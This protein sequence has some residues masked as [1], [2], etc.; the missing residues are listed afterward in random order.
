[1][2]IDDLPITPVNSGDR[3]PLYQQVE[4]DLR[5]L[6]RLGYLTPGEALPPEVTLSD[7]YGV[8]R[9]TVR[10]ALAH[11]VE[12]DLIERYAG[13]G[14]FVKKQADRMKFYLDRSFTN[15]MA[16]LDMAAHSRVLEQSTG[17]IT[18]QSPQALRSR[19]GEPCL[20]LTRLRLGDDEPIGLQTATV[21]TTG[22]PTL[23]EVDFATHSLYAALA[24]RCKLFI[25][26]IHHTVSAAVAGDLHANLLHI[27]QGEPLLVVKTVAH[28][29]SGE[30]IEVT[31]SFYRA[32]KYE[33]ST[34]HTY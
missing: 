24:E 27:A 30:V 7:V 15:Q 21:I 3:V 31:T 26:E 6:I 33:Y 11:L 32:D 1:M 8:G 10:L 22:C 20:R 2:H 16:A 23:A 9:Q 19:M 5:R 28:L 14:T 17:V 34:R 4:T 13:R 25:A 18:A 12:D 29:A